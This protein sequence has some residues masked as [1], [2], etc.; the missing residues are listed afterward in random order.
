MSPLADK[1]LT[2]VDCKGLFVFSAG[3]QQFFAEKGF[4]NQP[5]RCSNCREKKKQANP[6]RH[7]VR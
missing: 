2:C 6:S 3:E 7:T 1:T 4:T 5:K